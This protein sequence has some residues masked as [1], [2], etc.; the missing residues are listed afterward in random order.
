[1]GYTRF[2]ITNA[3]VA[4]QPP[5]SNGSG[6]ERV[7][8]QVVATI[9]VSVENVGQM[10]G[11]EVIQIYTSA[12][13]EISK[14]GLA[15]APRSLAGFAKVGVLAPGESKTASIAVTSD[16]IA[17]YDAEGGRWRVDEGVYSFFVGTSSRHIVTELQVMIE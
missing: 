12:S 10:A 13:P 17:W 7:R 9:T 3:A 6:R 16:S 8:G 2:Q 14:L 1:M 4:A 15:S 11:S 5:E